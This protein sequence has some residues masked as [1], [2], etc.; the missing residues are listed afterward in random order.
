MSHE[1][2]MR[3]AIAEGKAGAAK[4]NIVVGSVIVREG[5]LVAGGHNE[6]C[7]MC[8]AALVWAQTERVVIGALFPRTGGVRSQVRILD[9]LGPIIHPVDVVAEVLPA[10]CVALLPPDYR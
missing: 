5:R 1:A 2:W 6:A 9:L 4:G 10:E 8:A 7:P 3:A